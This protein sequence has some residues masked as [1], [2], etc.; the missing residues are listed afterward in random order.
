MVSSVTA[1]GRESRDRLTAS[2]H[3]NRSLN[4]EAANV[5]FE[6]QLSLD[7]ESGLAASPGVPVEDAREVSRCVAAL[8]HGLGPLRGG[9]PLSMRLLRGMHEC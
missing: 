7:D 1:L 2:F 8:E 4:R 3:G 6:N 9:L 5:S